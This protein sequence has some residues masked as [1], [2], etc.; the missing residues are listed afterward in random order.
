MRQ[1]QEDRIRL[2]FPGWHAPTAVTPASSLPTIPA[3]PDD[4]DQDDA[5]RQR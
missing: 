1:V 5:A 2:A 3:A 4:G